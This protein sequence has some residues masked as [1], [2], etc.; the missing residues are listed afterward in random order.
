MLLVSSKTI[1][2]P[3]SD[4]VLAQQQV[5]GCLSRDDLMLHSWLSFL[6]KWQ[7]HSLAVSGKFHHKNILTTK[8]ISSYRTEK[9]KDRE[10][11]LTK[12]LGRFF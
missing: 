8:L 2:E 6:P 5:S 10:V 7:I 11:T 1:V 3:G 12:N 4:V 9:A